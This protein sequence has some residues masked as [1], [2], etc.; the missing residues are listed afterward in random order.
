MS[1]R[2]ADPRSRVPILP[3]GEHVWVVSIRGDAPI[4]PLGFPTVE[5]SSAFKAR[6]LAEML[7]VIRSAEIARENILLTRLQGR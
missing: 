4:F 6:A 7:P 5:A 3:A 1:Y 2:S